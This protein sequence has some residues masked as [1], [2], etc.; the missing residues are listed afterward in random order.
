LSFW[1]F[2]SHS[3]AYR[4]ENLMQVNPLMMVMLALLPALAVGKP[5]A[6]RPALIVAIIIAAVSVLGV[7][8]KALPWFYQVNWEIIALMVPANLGLLWAVLELGRGRLDVGK[9]QRR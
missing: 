6:K 5:W 7:M 8:L 2:T 4:N 1:L 3:A 9:A